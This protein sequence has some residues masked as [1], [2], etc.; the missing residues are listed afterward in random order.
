MLSFILLFPF[1]LRL[2]VNVV[3]I[4]GV[5]IENSPSLCDLQS[6]LMDRGLTLTDT[7]FTNNV[8]NSSDITE[9][10]KAFVNQ[11]SN[12]SSAFV[13]CS[14][15]NARPFRFCEQCVV[16]Y[17]KAMKVYSDLTKASELEFSHLVVIDSL[18]SFMTRKNI[19]L[20]YLCKWLI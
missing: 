18:F 6:V 2:V 14:V 20:L 17:A 13:K 4:E 15:D 9:A 5:D 12:S 10:C 1:S 8:T 3:Y 19:I 16:H 7:D 11:F